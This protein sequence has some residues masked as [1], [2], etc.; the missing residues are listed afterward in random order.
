MRRAGPP[1]QDF[2]KAGPGVQEGEFRGELE[3]LM[4]FYPNSLL[5][6]PSNPHIPFKPDWEGMW[7]GGG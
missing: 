3:R 5:S 2:N 6:P 1:V 7:G 4:L